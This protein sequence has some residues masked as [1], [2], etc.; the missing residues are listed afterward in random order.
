MKQ[1]AKG[2]LVKDDTNYVHH[3]CF[4]G[5]M[6]L[7][8]FVFDKKCTLH[9]TITEKWRCRKD[10]SLVLNGGTCFELPCFLEADGLQ[11]VSTIFYFH[12]FCWES[13]NLDGLKHG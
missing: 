12:P 3:I 5:G 9:P 4:L 13:S 11:V 2:R 7:R 1:F 6:I 8:T 10:T